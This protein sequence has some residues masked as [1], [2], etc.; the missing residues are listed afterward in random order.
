VDTYDP[1]FSPAGPENQRGG[2]AEKWIDN[3]YNELVLF[4][5][6]GMAVALKRC[7]KGSAILRNRASLKR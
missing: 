1:L 4:M 3:D 2:Y 5:P 6:L 7:K